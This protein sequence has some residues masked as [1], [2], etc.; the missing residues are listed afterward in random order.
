MGECSTPRPFVGFATA[1][2]HFVAL[3]ALACGATATLAAEWSL[4]DVTTTLFAA[5]P[6]K[7]IDFSTRDF[8]GFDL[9]G[10]NFKGA[11]LANAN[12]FGADLSDAS[13]KGS[14]LVGANLDRTTLIRADFSHADLSNATMRKP[15]AFLT[16]ASAK[17]EAP[18]FEGAKLRGLRATGVYWSVNL[19]NA[20][21]TG[22]DFSPPSKNYGD[23]SNANNSRTLLRSCD[24]SGSI[25]AGANLKHASLRFS[26]LEGADLSNADLQYVDFTKANLKRANLAG[27]KLTGANFE[28]A[29][30]EGVQ[31]LRLPAP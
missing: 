25:L 14:S 26:S 13:L 28:G 6:G 19:R 29:N 4:R 24:L 17:S 12:L 15:A 18:S 10:T 21:L 22:A 31:G 7:A 9:S 23:H 20:D 2:R 8:S 5:E 1:A 3:V 16:E 27:A 30:L 11:T